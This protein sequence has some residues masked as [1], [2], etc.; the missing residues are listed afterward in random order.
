MTVLPTTRSTRC[1]ADSLHSS[2]THSPS[3]PVLT[4]ATAKPRHERPTAMNT[5]QFT[6]ITTSHPAEF[7]HE[8]NSK[9]VRSTAMKYHR[10][11]E[12]LGLTDKPARSTSRK[13]T[14]GI[15]SP[16]SVPSEKE[17]IFYYERL[18]EN[19]L[20][21][22]LSPSTIP[23]LPSSAPAV[24]SIVQTALYDTVASQSLPQTS[25]SRVTEYQATSGHSSFMLDMLLDDFATNQPREYL[26]DNGQ[27]VM[28]PMV[29][30]TEQSAEHLLS[31]L[32]Q[33][34]T[35]TS[36]L[37]K[38]FP[39]MRLNR[40]LISSATVLA[41]AW[42]DT[43]RNLPGDSDRTVLLKQGATA[44]FAR[45]QSDPN[46]HLDDSTITIMLHLMSAEMWS[47]DDS[48]LKFYEAGIVSAIVTSGGMHKLQDV[49]VA[50]FAAAYCYHSAITREATQYA[51]FQQWMPQDLDIGAMIPL[52]ESPLFDPTG[53]FATL[54]RIS[55]SSETRD[56][57]F[58]M[59]HLTDVFIESMGPATDLC[60]KKEEIYDGP[61]SIALLGYHNRSLAIH[62]QISS[63]LSAEV[64]GHSRSND[65]VY[66]ACRIAAVI[67][68]N[69]IKNL[70]KIGDYDPSISAGCCSS[71]G[72]TAPS[73]TKSLPEQLFE[74]LQKT[75]LAGIWQDM[76]GVL[77]WVCVVGAAAAHTLAAA[78]ANNASPSMEYNPQQSYPVWVRRNLDMHAF[79]TMAILV[80]QHPTP[81]IIAQKK[82][83][84]VQEVIREAAAPGRA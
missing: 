71:R 30:D 34:F 49:A 2:R 12:S 74:A 83:Y 28:L 77:Y 23:L 9:K 55:C 68:T 53:K 64:Q 11:M 51:V 57:I 4:S 14:T 22:D 65:W 17:D 15:V 60:I 6:F 38:W 56:I 25:M 37:R 13:S 5:P 33:E 29:A 45:R 73:P 69:A 63:L 66:E 44:M 1:S 72:D 75:D 47:Y 70:S 84:R 82:L 31:L 48:I 50:E 27:T 10:Q 61:Q 52:P 43:K 42:D 79:R 59:R 19:E 58:Q 26:I 80:P 46:T 7:K 62:T 21:L 40:D 16:P 20:Y 41:A 32:M 18:E 78:A 35:T 39:A 76:A 36:M 24:Q 3:I 81:I 67:Y 8:E 54:A